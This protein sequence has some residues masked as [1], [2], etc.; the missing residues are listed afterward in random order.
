MSWDT[1]SERWRFCEQECVRGS[2]DQHLW[3]EK[4]AGLAR[5]MVN[6]HDVSTKAWADLPEGSGAVLSVGAGRGSY[7]LLQS[8]HGSGLPSKAGFSLGRSGCLRQRAVSRMAVSQQ[9]L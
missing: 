9:Q 2:V 3:G 7:T 4:E 5:E 8:R 6:C 1:R